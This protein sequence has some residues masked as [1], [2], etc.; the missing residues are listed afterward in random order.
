MQNK[1][2]YTRFA[3]WAS[4]FCGQPKV[5]IAAVVLIL[6]WIIT[7]PMFHYSNTWQ[8]V[9]NTFTTIIT[10]LMVFVI[11]NSQ[12]R[13]T[14]AIQ[15]KLDELICATKGAA[16]ALLDVEDLDDQKLKEMNAKYQ[17]MGTSA[18]GGSDQQDTR[19]DDP[20]N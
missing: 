20:K 17:T 9:I 6:V 5:F 14:Q 15:L 2:I 16:N 18:R 8:L 7:G 10:F 4:N 11:Q 13:D 19:E 3:K 1:S 12:N